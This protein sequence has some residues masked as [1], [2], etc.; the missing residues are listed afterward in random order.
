[1]RHYHKNSVDVIKMVIT[2]LVII[3]YGLVRFQVLQASHSVFAN[4]SIFPRRSV[5]APEDVPSPQ[6][7][8]ACEPPR[9]S[10]SQA[11]C[12]LVRGP[13]PFSDLASTIHTYFKTWLISRPNGLTRTHLYSGYREVLS[14]E[15]LPFFACL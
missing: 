7:S 2:L 14:P 1:M 8:L 3:F 15:I 11:K 12:S 5:S 10:C 4:L 6:C 9:P 13:N